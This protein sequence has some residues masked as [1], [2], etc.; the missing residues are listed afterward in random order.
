MKN[1]I[2][3]IWQLPQNLIGFLLTR[4]PKKC[5]W[6]ICN[7]GEKI[8]VYLTSNV[9]GCGVSLGNYI[10]LDY[11]R[12]NYILDYGRYNNLGISKTVNHEHGHQKQSRY[13]G[14]FYLPF[15]GLISAFNNLWDRAFHKKWL[16]SERTRW[17]YSRY[18]EKWADN[19]GGVIRFSN[20][21]R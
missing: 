5:I 19:L 2:L 12:H 6:Y 21:K 13:L 3:W 1:I 16:N 17:Y 15:V 10:I 18:P 11:D 7:D 9:F 20:S 14:W 8:K 4:N